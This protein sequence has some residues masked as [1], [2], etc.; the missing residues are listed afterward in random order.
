[1]IK[2]DLYNSF[3]PV[4]VHTCPVDAWKINAEGVRD[5]IIMIKC[6]GVACTVLRPG[7]INNKGDGAH[8]RHD[9]SFDY[10]NRH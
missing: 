6:A 3:D 8:V 2:R 7:R 5:Y 9:T 1:M 4:S 10:N